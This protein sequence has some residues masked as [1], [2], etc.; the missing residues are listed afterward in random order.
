MRK[1]LL[2]LGATLLMLSSMAT[3]NCQAVALPASTSN[4]NNIQYTCQPPF[5]SSAAKPNIHFVID[6]TGSM[7]YGVYR[8]KSSSSGS[9]TST[10][11]A[12][13]IYVPTVNYYGLFKKDIYYNYNTSSSQWEEQASTTCTNTNRIGTVGCVSGNLLNYVTTNRIDIVRKI[14]TGGRTFSTDVLEHELQD[15]VDSLGEP[16]SSCVFNAGSVAGTVMIASAASI[17]ATVHTTNIYKI[18]ITAGAN[19]YTRIDAGSFIADGW[20]PGDVL[21]REGFTSNTGTWT[22]AAGG[23]TDKVLTVTTST[24]TNTESKIATLTGPTR[25]STSACPLV[26]AVTMVS[27]SASMK[28]NATTFNFTRAAGS[29]LTDGWL[30]GMTFVSSNFSNS[31]NNGLWTVAAVTAT[32]ITVTTAG[33]RTNNTAR[34]AQLTQVNAYKVRIQS[35]TP[36]ATGIIQDL[37]PSKADLEISFFSDTTGIGVDYSGG[38]VASSNT[39]KNQPLSNY[40]NAINQTTASG[41]TNTGPAMTAAKQFF[42][43]ETVTATYPATATDLVNKGV[44]NADPYFEPPLTGTAT[45]ANSSVAS[46]RKTFAILISDG[47]WNQP[48][49]SSSS[50]PVWPAFEMHRRDGTNDLRPDTDSPG[51]VAGT[52]SVNVYTVYAF[53]GSDIAGRNAMITTAIYGGFN[54]I[55]LNG[56]PYPFTN[57]TSPFVTP[58]ITA[59]NNITTSL[60]TTRLGYPLAQCNPFGT[61]TDACKEWDLSPSPH[62][63]LPYNFF[64]ADDGD[65][66]SNSLINAVNDIMGRVASSAAASILGNNDNA[67]ASLVQAMFYPEKQFDG[68][69]KA[70]WIGEVQ[71]FWYYLDPKLNNITI[72]V[73]NGSTSNKKLVLTE[74]QIA[75]FNFDGTYTKVFQLADTNG[76]GVQDNAFDADGKPVSPDTSIDIE[77]AST[78]WR[79]GKTLWTRT[80]ASRTIFTNDPTS[81][82]AAKLDFTTGNATTLQPYLDTTSLASDIISY[83]RG[84][85]VNATYGVRQRSVQIDTT[86]DVWKLGDVINSTPKMISEVRLN[87]YNLKAP[88]GYSDTSYDKYIKSDDYGKRGTAFVGANDGMLHAF[89][90]GSNFIGSTQ[91]VVAEIKNADGSTPPTDLG[92]ELWAF[93]PKNVLPYLQYLMLPAYRHMYFVDSTPL[94]LDA[95]IGM[96]NPNDSNGNALTNPCNTSTDSTYY[97]CARRTSLVTGT[98]Q[99][100]YSTTANGKGTSWRTVLVGSTGLGGASSSTK[101]ATTDVSITI[102]AGGT[103]TFTRT[104]GSFITDGWTNGM[105]F[106][107]KGFSTVVNNSTFVISANPTAF[108]ITCTPVAGLT[109]ETATVSLIQNVV[110]T[111]LADLGYSSYFALDVTE[112]INSDLIS[113]A[114]YPKLL[115]EF[116]DPRLGFST[117]TP[118]IIRIKDSNDTVGPA[119][120]GKWYAVLASGPTGPI[121]AIS[122]DFEGKSQNP[123]TIFILDLKTGALIKTFNNLPSSNAFNSANA[124]VH[125]QVSGMPDNAFAGSLSA[126]SIDVDKVD[127]LL[128]GFYSDDAVYIG[129]SR[130]GAEKPV[131]WNRGGILR[132]LTYNDSSPA[133]W[134]VTTVIDNIGPVTASVTKLQDKTDHKL[135]LF[136]GTGRYFVKGDDPTN[137]QTLFGIQDPCYYDAS[138]LASPHTFKAATSSSCTTPLVASMA[139]PTGTPA[140]SAGITGAS[141]STLVDQSTS[142]NIDTSTKK[143][144]SGKD[145]WY[146]N[147]GAVNGTN[148][149][150]RTITNPVSSTNGVITFT[151]FTPST[152]VCAY[153]GTT[154]VWAVKYNTGGVGSTNL[155][156]Q[157]LIQLSTGAF[158][159]IDVATAFTE[160]LNRETVQYKGVP[161]KSEPAITTNANHIPSKRILHIQE[162]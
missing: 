139:T 98:N 65:T 156:G 79:A 114:I 19:T 15:D 90:T 94:V 6:V 12:Q 115:W 74:D 77:D 28:V 88:G 26:P 37:Y 149:P 89:K 18:N 34:T 9:P 69:I 75:K 36:V 50:D 162:R 112:P 158:Q 48:D 8:S 118:A 13:A 106:T 137:V 134:K 42:K 146:I 10:V 38:G 61:W 125:T 130:A 56:K 107:A 110:K 25:T 32:E 101:A 150:K 67:G 145:G 1:I 73:D 51:G 99:L 135:W 24:G 22:V 55:D 33:M 84:S 155:K 124:A 71:A 122:S 126:S 119:R 142:I 103:T 141:A 128:P 60:D 86:T 82:T 62:T 136:F 153:G 2:S 27:T 96:T 104:A 147:L 43:Q 117:V 47:Q 39:S 78:L 131:S 120:N 59:A 140:A 44:G 121:N 7:A 14:L 148:Y 109:A 144:E 151:T 83:V 92:K 58:T 3:E 161:P 46:C 57:T 53:G 97:L 159:Q 76:N 35:S 41:G 138:N 81:T 102:S 31:Q 111:P 100:S 45:T 16:T 63:G 91:G 152:D 129:Y 64:E 20:K 157:I 54:D 11:P 133:N 40:V 70:S 17:S 87:S 105:K 85:D 95:S 68:T 123:L 93:I 127:S 132:L 49:T 29:F 52:Q 108:V 4:S 66:L 154:S 72:R 143:L 5:L 30:A 116:T 113:P 23:V 21:S 160:S 80:P